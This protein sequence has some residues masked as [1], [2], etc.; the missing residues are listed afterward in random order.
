MTPMHPKM[1][2]ALSGINWQGLRTLYAKEVQRYFKIFGQTLLAP[3][4]TTLLFLTVFGVAFGGGRSIDGLPYVE[5]LAPG[6]LMMSIL[7][8]SFANTSTSLIQ[9]KL[10]ENIVDT[11]MPPLSPM[12]LTTGFVLSGATRGLMVAIGVG[13]SLA[14][15]V[16]INLH[17]PGAIL[18]YAVGAA[19]MMASLGMM[20]GI[21]AEQFDHVS[22]ITNFVILP[23]SFLSGTF[24]PVTRFPELLQSVSHFNPFFYLIDGLRFGF[25]GHADGS[26]TIGIVYVTVVNILLWTI[27]YA[28]FRSGYKIK[29]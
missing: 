11:L 25:T 19:M 6:L 16:P 1:R 4:I 3:I 13:A 14:F 5:F 23:L 2:P 18:F 17:N 8:N 15:V 27:C 22:T 9:Q 12:E 21:W 29:D 26:I 28:M 24:F 10:N 7:Q 20:T